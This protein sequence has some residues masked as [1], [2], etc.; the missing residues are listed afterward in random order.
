MYNQGTKKNIFWKSDKKRFRKEINRLLE[1]G[2]FKSVAK[3][4]KSYISSIFLRE[5]NN[6]SHGLIL[7]LKNLNESVCV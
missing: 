4:T 6:E 2:F 7:N 1:R 5:K 3:D